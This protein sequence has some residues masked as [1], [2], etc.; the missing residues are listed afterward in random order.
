MGTAEERMRIL[1]MLELGTITADEAAK[2]LQ[3]LGASTSRGG[4]RAATGR[5]ARWLRVRITDT[6]T[7]ENKVSI[8]IPMGL[9]R[10]GIRMGARFVP[11][12][13]EIDYQ[14]LMDA[15]QGGETGKIFEMVDEDQGERVE[16]WA[17]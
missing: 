8:N 16:I 9:V 6:I 1:K 13:S 12:D 2:L 11:S 4:E 3:A 17:E 7:N 10:T 14:A 15:I 5:E